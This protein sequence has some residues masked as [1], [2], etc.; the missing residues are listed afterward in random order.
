MM[1]QG[2]TS[3]VQLGQKVIVL[4]VERETR[5]DSQRKNARH[6]LQHPKV[7]RVLYGMSVQDMHRVSECKDMNKCHRTLREGP[8]PLAAK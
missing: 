4:W 2:G 1:V 3:G 8:A 6:P 5:F 7:P